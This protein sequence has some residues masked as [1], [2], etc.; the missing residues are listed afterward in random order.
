MIKTILVIFIMAFSA[1]ADVLSSFSLP[2][3]GSGQVIQLDD[4]LS[5][6][7]VLLNFWATW[8]VGCIKELPE[9]EALKKKYKDQVIFVAV[10]AGEKK[11]KIKKFLKKYQFSYQILLDKNRNVSKSLGVLQ[12][13][14]TIVLE[15][16]RK[17]LYRGSRPPTKI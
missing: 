9:L 8:C 15:K 16:G 5:K 12:L 2:E 10:N 11:G 14:S 3:Y 13:P 4:L 17:V 7:K 6:K 1:S